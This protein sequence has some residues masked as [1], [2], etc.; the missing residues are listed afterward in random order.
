MQRS[1]L[2]PAAVYMFIAALFALTG[3][4]P[5]LHAEES[6]ESSVSL[7][8]D[9]VVEQKYPETIAVLQL[10]YG[11][12]V[13][14]D[15]R[16][17]L[18]SDTAKADGHTNIAYLFKAIAASEQVHAGNFRRILKS[19]GAEV[20][21]IDLSAIKSSTTQEN[22]KYATDVE[23]SEID[24]EYPRYIKRT[25]TEN[26][27]EANEY[28]NYAWEAER[29]HRELIKEIKS[30]TGFFFSTLLDR[31]RENKSVYYVNQNCGATVME[32][33]AEDCPICHKP[34]DTYIKVPKP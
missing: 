12:E 13:R 26:H 17:K 16:Y 9:A 33:P 15:H 6:S 5:L 24:K 18:Y 8:E 14:A 11:N 21:E 28:I 23:L 19:L 10:L 7:Q 3:S 31:F 25:A 29:Q 20:P 4:M 27:P 22:L 32:L 2:L 34:L 30:G 1:F